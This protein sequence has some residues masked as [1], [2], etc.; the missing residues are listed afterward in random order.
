VN[1]ARAGIALG[2]NL[3]D[4]LKMLQNARD[5]IRMIAGVRPPVAQSAIY[6]TTPVNCE[7]RAGDFYN[8]VIEIGFENSAE[9]LLAA[10]REIEASLGRAGEHHRNVS[11]TI[12][13][14]LLYFGEL[15]LEQEQLQLPHPRVAQRAFVLLPLADIE[16]DLRLPGQTATVRE[17]LARL[18]P[19][20]AVTRLTDKW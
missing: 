20:E 7:P 9:L 15:Q 10:L 6:Q 4:R 1:P 12:D 11:R 3:G 2:S 14:D 13:L 18:D 17:L 16:P 8:A 5:Q 19:G